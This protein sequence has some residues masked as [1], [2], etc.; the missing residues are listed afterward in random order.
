[1]ELPDPNSCSTWVDI[2]FPSWVLADDNRDSFSVERDL[3]RWSWWYSTASWADNSAEDIFVCD[4]TF[5]TLAVVETAVEDALAA[6][7][8]IEDDS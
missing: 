1:M 8:D 4:D 6:M 7:E 3:R 2:T 5:F